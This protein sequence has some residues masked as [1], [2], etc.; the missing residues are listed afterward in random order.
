[1][2]DGP[3]LKLI[4]Q[5][6]TEAG[7]VVIVLGRDGPWA[8]AQVADLMREGL[9]RIPLPEAK[10]GR[11]LMFEVVQTMGCLSW[12]GIRKARQIAAGIARLPNCK[13]A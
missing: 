10:H 4:Q 5:A 12:G 13:A 7:V 6:A 9:I 8:Q 11:K 2:T 1:M 3:A